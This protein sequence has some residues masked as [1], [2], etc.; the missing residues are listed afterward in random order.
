MKATPLAAVIGLILE[1][2]HD[3]AAV[4]GAAR[5][6]LTHRVAETIATLAAS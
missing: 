6:A 1:P 3:S 2:W 5:G 4:L